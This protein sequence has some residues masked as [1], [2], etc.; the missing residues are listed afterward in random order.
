VLNVAFL[1][2]P[3][4]AQ[5]HVGVRN[6]VFALKGL[7]ESQGHG[8]HLIIIDPDQQWYSLHFA[9]WRFE[10]DNGAA[11]LR[12]AGPPREMLRQFYGRGHVGTVN[13]VHRVA[14]G[15]R[16]PSDL[17]DLCIITAPWAVRFE[18]RLPSTRL[19]GLV[20][21]VIPN[22]HALV[23]ETHPFAFADEHRRGYE[24]Y[25]H[26]CDGIIANSLDTA[27]SFKQLFGGG[28][29]V[30]PLPP[31]VPKAFW[32][33]SVPQDRRN[34]SLLLAGPLDLRKGLKQLPDLLNSL[35]PEC[36]S[37]TMFGAIRCQETDAY[38]FFRALRTEKLIWYPTI[39]SA[40]LV[41]LYGQ[42]RLLLFP[43]I[44]E[45]LGIPIIEAQWMGA[46][47]AVRAKS[48]MR[49]LALNGNLLLDERPD[50]KG[51]EAE[52]KRYAPD[53]IEILEDDGFD[54]VQLAETAR[55]CFHPDVV[56]AALSRL[57]VD[58]VNPG[59]SLNICRQPHSGTS[60]LLARHQ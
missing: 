13:Q 44:E 47:V 10:E 1:V 12:I 46:R 35:E 52:A 29:R 54:H 36:D 57:G 50:P 60:P 49:D 23:K 51:S 39:S 38:E 21:D 2:D 59:S 41:R 58:L 32:S 25:L 28:E 16:F 6:Y 30:Q 20:H 31:L 45:G 53:L 56:L 42:S 4:F 40:E 9:D 34:R 37:I 14:L 11:D 7:I 43:S 3:N 33:A 5:T 18:D 24:Y 27:Q 17:F 26:H 48:P 22:I 15:S 19:L 55:K 8:A